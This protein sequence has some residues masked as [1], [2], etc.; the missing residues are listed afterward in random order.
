MMMAVRLAKLPPYES[1]SPTSRWLAALAGHGTPLAK[2]RSSGQLKEIWMDLDLEFAEALIQ[3]CERI[4][5]CVANQTIPP[6]IPWEEDI[7]GRC[8]YGHICLPEVKH[9]AIDLSAQPELETHLNRRAELAPLKK[10]YE[11]L[12]ED[13]KQLF[14]KSES[15]RAIVGTWLL[16]K[17]TQQRNGKEITVVKIDKLAVE[18]KGESNGEL[19]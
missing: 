11:Q 8:Q 2:D 14:L 6:P 4:N 9:T 5:H 10:E 15:I 3:K 13:V 19:C 7:C 16:S 17:R 12:D 18:Q 1:P